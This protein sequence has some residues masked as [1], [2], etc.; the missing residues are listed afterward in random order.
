MA[1]IRKKVPENTDGSFFVDQTC[2]DCE[3]C[4][5][6]APENF[7]DTGEHTYVYHQPDNKQQLRDSLHA[8]LAC[9]VGAIGSTQAEDI[10]TAMQD[11]PLP[12][13][14]PVYY[15]GFNSAKSYGANSY[16][17]QHVDGNWLIDSPKY[18]P[19][20]AQRFEELGGIAYI[21]LTHQDDVA[22][23]ARYAEHF[24]AKRIIHRADSTAQPDAEI[25]I[26]KNEPVFIHPEFKIIPTP[27]HTKGH[28]VLLF[29]NHF[30]LSGDH[31]AWSPEL[32][33]LNAFRTHCWYSWEH[34]TESMERLS[35]EAFTWVLPGHGHRIHL[36]A[37]QMK[38]DML[39]LVQRMSA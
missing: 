28:M 35:H 37:E 6:L 36:S 5:Q 18:L 2:I 24:G 31:L 17:I 30:L 25:I 22:D 14:K 26:D 38:K 9:P 11:F 21:F 7:A 3:T 12:I 34:Q 27:G 15:C 23:A 20:L 1:D 39:S 32:N 19:Y 16:F 13:E 29:R 33:T 8:L 4:C 10:Q